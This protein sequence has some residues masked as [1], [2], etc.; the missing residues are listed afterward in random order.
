MTCT[1]RRARRATACLSFAAIAAMLG[2]TLEA[3]GAEAAP[4]QPHIDVSVRRN[5]LFV[6]GGRA[7]E[8]IAIRIPAA[9]PHLVSVD[10]GDDGTPEA[11]VPHD[12]FNRVVVFSG[13]GNDDV[14]VDETPGTS[15]PFT[16]PYAVTGQNGNDTLR[17]TSGVDEM[18]G[19]AGAD[20]VDGNGGND[21]VFLG[22]GDDEFVW[23]PGDGSDVIEGLDGTDL[24]TFNGSGGN[25]TFRAAANGE[26]LRFTRNLGNIVM[27]TDD[28]EHVDVNALG[29]SD[30]VEVDDLS[31]TDVTSIDVDEG[32]A[33]GTSTPDGII[34]SVF[35]D[36]TDGA[37]D[38]SVDGSAGAATISGLVT[39]VT[40]ADADT[41]DRLLVS[42]RAGNDV[43]DAS[44]FG[45]GS[46]H[47][48]VLG[49]DG[50]DD[51]FGGIGSDTILAGSGRDLVDGNQGND[52]G[53]LDS[54]NDVF[55]WDPGDGSD[56]IDGE[57]GR[58][59]MRFNG[60]SGAEVF[61][62]TA[63]GDRM[64]FTR[65]VGNIV[66]DTERVEQVNLQA[67][68][69]ADQLT[70]GDLTGTVMQLFD[71]NLAGTPGGSGDDG[72]VDDI[73]VIGTPDDD[74]IDVTG[75]NGKVRVDGL[76]AAVRL[77]NAE[78]T[79]ALTID[80]NGGQDAVDSTGLAP[81]TIQLT[82]I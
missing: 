75:D 78:A 8:V 51:V 57:Q 9:A 65:D 54:G 12:Q 44:A 41:F 31:M 21:T 36:G 59:T 62:A 63:N 52:T 74:S 50:D 38:M 30:F 72:E 4:P 29:G 46:P 79:D 45:A 26:R 70:V 40:L 49:G 64:V 76:T 28:V 37:D 55:V 82:V 18:R 58:D 71:T 10:L 2:I 34:D 48:S 16:I 68:G 61:A 17:G 73:T 6:R 67:S 19:G 7:A 1:S 39:T 11:E 23:D 24:M 22:S 15:L 53:Q 66:M 77:R 20:L 35:V 42:S 43:V 13:G 47:L 60:S 33:L 69:G 32:A 27:D 3:G 5:T 81:G 56:I 25:E 80:G 14:R